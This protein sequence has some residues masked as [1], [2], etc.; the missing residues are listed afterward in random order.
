MEKVAV[1][2]WK[3]A[4]WLKEQQ[5]EAVWGSKTPGLKRICQ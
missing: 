3:V 1:I 5:H 4:N 2:M